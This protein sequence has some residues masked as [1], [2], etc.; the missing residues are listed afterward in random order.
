MKV[1]AE[2]GKKC[3][4]E[5]NELEEVVALLKQSISLNE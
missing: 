1:E 5:W 4:L 3:L 2:I